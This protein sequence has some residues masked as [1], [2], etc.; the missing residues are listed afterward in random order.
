MKKWEVTFTGFRNDLG[1][2][3]FTMPV[4]AVSADRRVIIK[5][6]QAEGF[7]G[8]GGAANPSP[9]KIVL[10]EGDTGPFVRDGKRFV[11]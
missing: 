9:E 1:E 10:I 6:L 3:K 11:Y 7:T 4:K 5:A 2:G 8:K